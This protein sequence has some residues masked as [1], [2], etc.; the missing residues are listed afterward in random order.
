MHFLHINSVFP[1]NQC[2]H[3]VRIVTGR[4]QQMALLSLHHPCARRF[5]KNTNFFRSLKPEAVDWFNFAVSP[6]IKLQCGE[7][8]WSIFSIILGSQESNIF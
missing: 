5:W 1:T 8:P 4:I 7:Q 6:I 3:L 2:Y